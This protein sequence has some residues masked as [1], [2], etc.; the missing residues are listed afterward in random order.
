[1]NVKEIVSAIKADKPEITSVFFV[2]CGAS[3]AD[4]YPGK[5]F[6]DAN[7][8][9]LRASLHTA[10]EFYYSTPA[11]VGPDSIVVTCSLS[12]GTP[13][14]VAATKKAMELGAEVIAVT[15]DADSPLAKAAKYQIIHGFAKDYAAKME[16]MTNVLALACE[17]LNTYEGYAL[18]D[19][20][21][22]GFSK[23]YDLI[24]ESVKTLLPR[25]QAFGKEYKDMPMLY[26]MSSGAT[27]MVAYSFSMFLMMEMQWVPSSS[28]NCGEFFHGPF[29]LAEKD[30]PYL[31][32]MNDGPTR[33]MDARAMTF[34]QRFDT[35][36]TV[37]DAK[38]FGLSSVIKS[39]VV[40][41]FNPM[42]LC[43]VLRM[44]AEQLALE[45]NHPLTMRR[46]MWKLEY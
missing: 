35:K 46:Y 22:D 23:I 31:L 38:D 40:E 24:N 17:I 12:G 16:K 4:L 8:K 41:Y 11:A 26:V 21:Q 28:Y 30:V 29:E 39:S 33:P 43:G 37:V 19:D 7:A 45:R 20:M 32:L 18:Y 25:A 34:L 10:N 9:K 6:L 5:Y 44:Y 15:I 1:M 13:E 27:A 42:L 14:T 2:G 3:Q 36:L